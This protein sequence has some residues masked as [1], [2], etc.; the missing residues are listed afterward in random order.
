M[1]T[2]TMDGIGIAALLVPSEK[3]DIDDEMRARAMS[4]RE[5]LAGP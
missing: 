2:S 1:C 4:A 3:R 5:T